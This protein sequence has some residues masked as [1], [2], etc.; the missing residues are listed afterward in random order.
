MLCFLCLHE[1]HLV[2]QVESHGGGRNAGS[3]L[4][5]VVQ[6]LQDSL[7]WLQRSTRLREFCP[8]FCR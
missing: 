2:G 1:D 7:A 4:E 5:T 8:S 6:A 3:E